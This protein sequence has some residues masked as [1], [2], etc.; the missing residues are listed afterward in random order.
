MKATLGTH[1]NV[2]AQCQQDPAPATG[3]IVERGWFQ[4]YDALPT[5]GLAWFQ[6]WDLADKGSD[7]SHSHVSG[8]LWAHRPGELYL[9]D[10]V[11]RLMNYP[12]TKRAF[13]ARQGRAADGTINP[14]ARARWPQWSRAMPIDVEEKASGVQLVQEMRRA[15][16]AINP[17]QPKDSKADRL[18]VASDVIEAGQVFIPN[19]PWAEAWLDE[20]VGFPR[21]GRDDRVDTFTAAVRRFTGR[22]GRLAAALNRLAK[23][24]K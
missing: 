20:V 11:N 22:D 23:V 2:A 13:A 18:R 6:T 15:F 24:M 12:D 4:R 1:A 5:A 21:V 8:T 19:A 9:V 14:M 16:P 10:E 3:G 17:T 7:A